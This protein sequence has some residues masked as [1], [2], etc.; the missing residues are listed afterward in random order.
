MAGT[1]KST[2]AQTISRTL[3]KQNRLAASLFFLKSQGDLSHT[4]KLFSI[5]ARQLAATSRMLKLYICEAI[6]E[7]ENISQQSMRNQWTKLVY[8][9]LMKLDGNQQSPLTLVFVIDALDECKS[10][11]DIRTLLQLLMEAG[12]FKNVQLKVLVTS[13]PEISS[14]FRNISGSMHEDFVLHYISA[15][16][17]W[18]DI[19]VFLSHELGKIKEEPLLPFDWPGKQKLE[20][21]VERSGELFIYVATVCRF[22]QDPKWLPEDRLDVVLQGNNDSQWPT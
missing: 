13:R 1:G 8:Q 20:I 10:Q 5:I 9:P 22:I 6:A 14:Q 18:H 15:A 11:Q 21:L 19:A 12:N 4:D 17:I 16:I 3:T 2:I 7:H